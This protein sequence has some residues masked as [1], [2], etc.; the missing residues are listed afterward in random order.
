VYACECACTCTM[1][2]HM[3]SVQVRALR[4]AARSSLCHS[5]HGVW[6]SNGGG[7]DLDTSIQRANEPT[8]RLN[9]CAPAADGARADNTSRQS[10]RAKANVRAR[11]REAMWE[12][13]RMRECDRPCAPPC[14][15]S[16]RNQTQITCRRHRVDT[17]HHSGHHHRHRH[18]HHHHHHL[19]LR[20]HPPWPPPPL[21]RGIR[22]RC[23]PKPPQ[24][25]HLP[26][27]TRSKLTLQGKRRCS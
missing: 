10:V 9:T 20:S 13:G 23:C 7:G 3:L 27:R 1:R 21:P 11:A 12:T 26:I 2:V 18:H 19:G 4:N 17:T 8:P 25:L 22:S 6:G 14:P 5:T 24:R 15:T 16:H